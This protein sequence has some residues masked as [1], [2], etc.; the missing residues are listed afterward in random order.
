MQKFIV[1]KKHWLR[2][3]TKK[4]KNKS[5]TPTEEQKSAPL[6][7]PT[8]RGKIKQKLKR[9]RKKLRDIEI[10]EEEI[11]NGKEVD[12]GK[13]SKCKLKDDFLQKMRALEIHRDNLNDL[14]N[15]DT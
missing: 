11:K 9:L 7:L 15:L 1:R 5:D 10:I 13:R 8:H 6:A 3:E 12:Q 4:K 2:D 14:D